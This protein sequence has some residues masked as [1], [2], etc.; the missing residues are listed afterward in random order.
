M[1][2]S[3]SLSFSTGQEND[4]VVLQT[5]MQG[6]GIALQINLIWNIAQFTSTLSSAKL[7]NDEKEADYALLPRP[8]AKHSCGIKFMD[9]Y[10]AVMTKKLGLPLYNKQLISKLL[11]N[12]MEVDYTNFFRLLSNI[13]A[14]STTPDEE[15]L[16]PL[17]AALLD[18]GQERKEAWTPINKI[19]QF[20]D[21]AIDMAEQGDFEE[22]RRL[23]K[24][25]ESPYDEQPGNKNKYF[26][27]HMVSMILDG[28][29]DD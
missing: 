6:A 14:D 3:E 7:I 26:E 8:V 11:L 12:N 2:K 15:L 1:S 22:V 18:I 25:I 21:Y 20:Y 19:M 9:D 28:N 10:Q 27:S 4:S 23:L 5:N 24:V 17:K 13:K 29:K 16:V